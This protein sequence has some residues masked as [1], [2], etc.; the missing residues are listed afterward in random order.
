LHF[1]NGKSILSRVTS[2]KG[3]VAI[4]LREKGVTN[5]KIVGELYL[6]SLARPPLAAEI[7]LGLKFFESYKE[8]RK[9]AAEDL[10]WAL[11]NSKDFMLV[12]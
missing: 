2:G 12:H 8:K 10:M 1:I 5:E 11:L 3:R 6:W 4:L 7:E 9:E